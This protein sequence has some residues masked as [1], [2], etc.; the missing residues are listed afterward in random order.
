MKTFY[1]KQTGSGVRLTTPKVEFQ[2]EGQ[3]E[4]EAVSEQ[5]TQ[6]HIRQQAAGQ[7]G[8]AVQQVYQRLLAEFRGAKAA[9]VVAFAIGLIIGLV[10][11][12]WYVWPV[13][14]TGGSFTD[15]TERDKVLVVPMASDV[16]AN[17][18]KTGKVMQ[19]GHQWQEMSAYACALA[20]Q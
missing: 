10:Y 5:P 17:D 7:S 16:N 9:V 4:R 14:W 18:P 3:A 11:L 6:L 12:G 15:M 8:T 19:I 13:E 2:Q 1:F 20:Q